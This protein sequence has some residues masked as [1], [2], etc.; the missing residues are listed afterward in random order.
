MTRPVIGY[1]GMTHLGLNSAVAAANSGLSPNSSAT[2]PW[3]KT[4]STFCRTFVKRR[5]NART[6][7]LAEAATSVFLLLLLVSGNAIQIPQW[8][9]R[10]R[11]TPDRSVLPLTEI[12][13]PAHG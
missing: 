12:R 1:A 9:F 5:R 3:G 7:A 6:R 11:L 4:S 2:G 10:R 8:T 13:Q